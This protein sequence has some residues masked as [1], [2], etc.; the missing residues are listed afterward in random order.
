MLLNAENESQIFL[1][2]PRRLD[3]AASLLAAHW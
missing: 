1:L 3:T 2:E